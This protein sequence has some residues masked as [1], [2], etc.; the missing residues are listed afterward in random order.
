MS[1]QTAALKETDG[2]RE[3]LL[4]PLL[5]LDEAARIIRRSHWSIRKYVASGLIRGVRIGRDLMIEPSEIRRFIEH[6]R[7]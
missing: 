6:Q 3:S 2:A 7:S 4:E 5:T 1:I